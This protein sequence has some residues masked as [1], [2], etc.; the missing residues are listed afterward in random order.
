MALFYVDKINFCASCSRGNG[1][2]CS[3][4][5]ADDLPLFLIY[6]DIQMENDKNNGNTATTVILFLCSRVTWIPI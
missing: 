5:I 1:V 2:L 3:N 4:F 6:L